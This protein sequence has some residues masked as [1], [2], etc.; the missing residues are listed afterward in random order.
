MLKLRFASYLA[1][2]KLCFEVRNPETDSFCFDNRISSGFTQL[3]GFCK[4]SIPASLVLWR[5][6]LARTTNYQLIL[7]AVFLS[8]AGETQ[9]VY[10]FSSVSDSMQ[11]LPFVPVPLSTIFYP[12]NF[13]FRSFAMTELLDLNIEIYCVIIS[14]FI[15]ASEVYF[16]IN[17]VL[18]Q[19]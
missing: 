4:N 3:L 16:H 9:N 7:S 15:I 2:G 12:S 1:E 18:N 10:S 14:S 8:T 17:I 11:I 5:C 19:N 6:L 13:S